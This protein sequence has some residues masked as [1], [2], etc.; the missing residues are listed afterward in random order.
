[1]W[2]W[3]SL[4]L[5]LGW[6]VT[7]IYF[8]S[9][10]RPSIKPVIDTSKHQQTEDTIKRLKKACADNNADAAKDA[11]LEWGQQQFNARSLGAIAD[12]C[13][14]RLR[15]EILALNQVLYGKDAEQWQGKKLF[16]TFTENK[17][18]TKLA[19]KTDDGLEP[20][21]RL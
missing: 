2:I 6:L 13:E 7:V 19:N 21:Y 20:L 4:F 16:Q 14:A 10:K 17:A 8:L 9:G 3:A 5:A 11:L 15:D 12:L 18:R 1:M